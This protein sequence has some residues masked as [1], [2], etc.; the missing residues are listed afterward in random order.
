MCLLLYKIYN[1]EKIYYNELYNYLYLKKHNTLYTSVNFF[2]VARIQIRR[3]RRWPVI[4]VAGL[5]LAY[6]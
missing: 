2:P 4:G 1:I 3:W 5:L 6:Y